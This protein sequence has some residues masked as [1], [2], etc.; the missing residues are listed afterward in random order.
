LDDERDQTD[1]SKFGLGLFIYCANSI[2]MVTSA[3]VTGLL[4][5]GGSGITAYI[6]TKPTDYQMRNNRMMF[7]QFTNE[8]VEERVIQRI[9][10]DQQFKTGDV[11]VTRR[12]TGY[13]TDMMLLSGSQASGVA[14]IIVNAGKVYVAEC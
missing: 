9:K 1:V 7:A 11:F 2:E 6:D 8:Y 14:I 13:A 4:W 5:V 10:Q 3:V 12:W